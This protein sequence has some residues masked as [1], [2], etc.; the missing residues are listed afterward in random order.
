MLTP[1]LLLIAIAVR[2][3]S[4]GPAIFR[5]R[6]A[7]KAGRSFECYKFRTMFQDAADIRNIDGSTFSSKDDSRVT[8]VGRILR[9]TS[10]DE[11]PQLINVLKGEMSLVGP[12]PDQIDQVQL[13]TQGEACRL[14]VKPGLT[15]LAQISGRNSISWETR[16]RL[17]LQYVARQ[18]LW[19]DTTIFLRTIPYVIARR[20]IFVSKPSTRT[21]DGVPGRQI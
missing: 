21:N 8:R 15:G 13:Y 18:S 20:G 12:R 9:R 4:E 5:Q 3:N 6:R 1:V 14:S 10:I 19:L 17:D 11:L 2:L 7:G 16:K